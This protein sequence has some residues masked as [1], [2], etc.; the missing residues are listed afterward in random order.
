[1]A[2]YLT[3]THT[4]LFVNVRMTQTLEVVRMTYSL[5]ELYRRSSERNHSI[6]RGAVCSNRK[7]YLRRPLDQRKELMA[8]ADYRNKV[9]N[10]RTIK[11]L[12]S[13]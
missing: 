1:M 8:S 5:D 13:R 10:G 3:V 4:P 9:S 2:T 12:S 6:S 11:V 7:T